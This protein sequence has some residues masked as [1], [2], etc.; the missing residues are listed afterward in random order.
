MVAE[1]EA[2]AMVGAA[3]VAATAAADKSAA[4]ACFFA[5]MLVPF[6]LVPIATHTLQKKELK[7]GVI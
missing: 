7:T 5:P 6:S 2:S 4:T 1:V 3:A